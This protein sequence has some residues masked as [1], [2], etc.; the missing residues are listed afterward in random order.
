[1]CLRL[2]IHTYYTRKRMFAFEPHHLRNKPKVKPFC[3]C[4]KPNDHQRMNTISAA[5]AHIPLGN[6]TKRGSLG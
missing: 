3:F 5:Q 1:M 4:Y 2:K 6:Q